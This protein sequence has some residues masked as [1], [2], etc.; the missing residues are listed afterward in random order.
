MILISPTTIA[1][2]ID[3]KVT[4][5]KRLPPTRL[6][7]PGRNL[8]ASKSSLY[9]GN[10]PTKRMPESCIAVVSMVKLVKPLR[11]RLSRVSSETSHTPSN[12][13]LMATDSV[14]ALLVAVVYMA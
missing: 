10:I 5:K 11:S 4:T 7:A 14:Y 6:V 2:P 3:A 13:V 1:N 8:N 9:L 12:M